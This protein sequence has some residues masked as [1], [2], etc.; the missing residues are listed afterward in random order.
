MT[1]PES[2]PHASPQAHGFARRNWG[3][4]T[5]VAL[6]VVPCLVFMIWAGA[7]LSYSY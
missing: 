2:E 4:L 7:A 6:V 5:L 3:K 1:N